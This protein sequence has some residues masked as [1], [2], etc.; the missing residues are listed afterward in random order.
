VL[1]WIL[2]LYLQN[3]SALNTDMMTMRK[4]EKDVLKRGISV[5]HPLPVKDA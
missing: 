5:M 3:A 4:E 1:A 2:Y